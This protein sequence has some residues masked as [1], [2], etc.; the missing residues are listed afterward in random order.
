M[1]GRRIWIAA[2]LSFGGSAGLW[3]Q[4][5]PQ[6]GARELMLTAGKSLVVN[7]SADIERIAVG[8]GDVAEARAIGLREVLLDGKS[9]GETSLIIWQTGGNKL[10][11]DVTVQPNTALVRSKIENVRREISQELPGEAITVTMQ[12]DIV[13]LR[14]TAKDLTSAQRAVTIASTA[15]KLPTFF[16]WTAAHRCTDPVEGPVCHSQ[17]QQHQRPGSEPVQPGRNQHGRANVHGAISGSHNLASRR[18]SNRNPDGSPERVP[19]P[20]RFESWRDHQGAGNRAAWPRFWRNP[21]FWQLTASKLHSGGRG[22]SYPILQGGQAGLGTITVAFR[23]FGVRIISAARN[24]ARNHPPNRHAGSQF[25]R[26]RV[27]PDDTG[28]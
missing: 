8:F 3:G 25:A 12:N 6:Q 22:V 15:E 10:F 4:T 24:A 14:G 5:A 17:P 18:C 19:V 13:F 28:L 16:M 11:F 2:L 21:T 7:T 27:R 26:L 9:A 20:A 23:E 1:N